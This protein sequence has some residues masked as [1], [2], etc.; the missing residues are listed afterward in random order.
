[1]FC[2]AKLLCLLPSWATWYQLFHFCLSL[3][4]CGSDNTCCNDADLI[5]VGGELSV[6]VQN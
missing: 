4:I 6:L 3:L 2:D 1:M 5:A